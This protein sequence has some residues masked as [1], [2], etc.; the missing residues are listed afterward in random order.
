[1][2]G[3]T[4]VVAGMLHHLGVNMGNF[5]STPGKRGYATFED[6][7]CN[8]FKYSVTGSL[9]APRVMKMGFDFPAYAEKR[10]SGGAPGQRCGFKSGPQFALHCDN[11]WLAEHVELIVVNR[12]LEDSIQSHL[13][14]W[15]ELTQPDAPKTAEDYA[16]QS[17][18]VAWAF[19]LKEI[20]AIQVPPALQ[21]DYYSVLDVPMDTVVDL[22]ATFNL[23]PTREQE[24][25]ACEFCDPEMRH[26]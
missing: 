26:V 10:I 14:I 21:L 19:T 8:E 3:G 16:W 11:G 7:D 18:S 12:P 24:N 1:M 22:S 6:I 20:L 13:D 17:A 2:S 5:A 25:A 9:P 4:S 15:S 23:N